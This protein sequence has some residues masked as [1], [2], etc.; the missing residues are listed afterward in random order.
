ML[1]DHP[2]FGLSPE[3][4]VSLRWVLAETQSATIGLDRLLL[5]KDVYALDSLLADIDVIFLNFVFADTKG[6]IGHRATG[7]IPVRAGHQGAKAKL[8]GEQDDWLGFIPKREMPGQINPARNWVGTANHDVRPDSFPYYY[9][10]HFAPNYRYERIRQILGGTEK[11]GPAEH[12]QRVL[13][14]TNTHTERFT[15]III[16]ALDGQADLQALRQQ[17][18]GW[19]FQDEVNSVGAS[20]FHLIHEDLVRAILSDDLPEE[21]LTQLL[22]MRYY[23]LQRVD[24]WIA[25]GASPWFDDL[26][27]PETETLEDLIVRAAHS[28]Q[29]RLTE[30]LGPNIEDWQW[31]ALHRVVF[32]SPLRTSGTGRDWWAVVIGQPMVPVRPSIAVSMSWTAARMKASGSARCGWWLTCPTRRRSGP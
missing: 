4:P 14:V 1:S 24:E 16:D 9:S 22:N 29:E 2:F 23:W 19:D 31:G 6:N 8:P 13:D 3:Q 20:I 10:S 25:E 15:P 26:R 32:V 27:T 28:A 21:L 12:W 17:L 7:E 11:L 18:E 5:A 30:L